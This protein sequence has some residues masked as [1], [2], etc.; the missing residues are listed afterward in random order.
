MVSV[1]TWLWSGPLRKF[2]PEHVNTLQRMFAHYL[3]IPHRFICVADSPEGFAPGVEY[4]ATPPEARAV[5]M[6]ASPEGARFPSCYR[7]LW[8]FSRAARDAFGDRFL[9]IDIDLLLLRNINH[10]VEHQ[11]EFVGWRPYRDWGNKVRFGGGIYLMT[12]GARDF[13][14]DQFN[15]QQSIKDAR[16]AGYRGSD[17]AWLS[18]KLAPRGEAY[19]GKDAGLYSVRDFRTTGNAPGDACLVQF[20]GNEKPWHSQSSWARS[21]WATFEGRQSP[22]LP[23]SL[24]PKLTRPAIAMPK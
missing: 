19:W 6:F 13:V 23:P 17:Q 22:P 18:Y 20:N 10:V 3:T 24:R 9:T 5:G 15:G 8:G 4:F 14:W 12:A 21:Q 11:A 16:H 7:R 1:V 2:L